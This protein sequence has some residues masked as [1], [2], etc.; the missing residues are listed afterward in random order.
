MG[1][2]HVVEEGK[3]ETLMPREGCYDCDVAEKCQNLDQKVYD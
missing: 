2:V 1:K 3:A